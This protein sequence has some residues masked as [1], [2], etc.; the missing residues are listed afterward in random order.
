M[1]E[2]SIKI[3]LVR[4]TGLLIENDKVLIV[5]QDVMETRQWS[6]PGGR[7]EFGETVEQCLIREFK[8]ET[9]LKI[10]VK[11]LLYVTDRFHKNNHIVHILFL[12]EKTGGKLRSGDELE[13]ES[14]TIK[15]LA[16]IPIDR[17]LEYGFPQNMYQ[18][19]KSGFPDRGSYKGDFEKF[20]GKL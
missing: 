12:V 16:M 10:A 6:L 1:R 3:I 4:P 7:L 8:E 17:L 9:G 2:K 5:K 19:I 20:Y 13:L 11:E 14:E 15:E 18:V